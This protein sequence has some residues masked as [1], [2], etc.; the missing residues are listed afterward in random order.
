MF[1]TIRVS[2]KSRCSGK[3]IKTFDEYYDCS[4]QEFH[5]R[6]VE[7]NYRYA[8]ILIDLYVTNLFS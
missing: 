2:F 6:L 7:N 1:L 5:V 3:Y 4:I 8:I